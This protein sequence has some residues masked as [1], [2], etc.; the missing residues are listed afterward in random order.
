[1]AVTLNGMGVAH[2]HGLIAAGHYDD[3]ASWSFTADDGNALLGASGDDWANYAAFHLGV[4]GDAATDTK[5]RWDYPYG[6][7]GKVYGAALRAI[8]SRAAQQNETAIYD[9]AGHCLDL[10]KAAQGKSSGPII[11]RAYSALTIKAFDDSKR[12][13]SGIASTPSVD[14]MGDVVDPMGAVFT[15]P[16]PLLLDHNSRQ[17]VGHVT[18]AKPNA[19]GIPFTAQIA[20]VGEPGTVKDMVDGAWQLVKA[21]LRS[22]VSIGFSALKYE[23]MKDGGYQFN[24]W[25][26]LELSLVTIPANQDAVIFDGKS[27]GATALSV[28]KSID[29]TLLAASGK[30]QRNG[31]KR[32]VSAGVSATKPIPVVKAQ[33]A[34]PK[35]S[36]PVAD[37]ISAF[38]TTRTAK[39]ARM[40]EIMSVAA[41]KGETLDAAATEEYDTLEAE[42]KAIDE[43][44]VRLKRHEKT[45]VARAVD[46]SGAVDAAAASRV[47]AGLTVPAAVRAASS[48]PKGMGFTRFCMAV[49]R[50]KGNLMQAERMVSLN[51]RWMAETPDVIEV[52]RSAV[53]AGTTTD[54]TWAGP[55]VQYQNL[56]SEFIEYLRPLTIIGRIP[57]IRYVPFKV[58]IPRQTGKSTAGWV[59]EGQAK[60]VS[61]LA[62]DSVTMD[63][64]TISDI[65]IFSQQLA[66]LSQPSV[67]LLIR[68][69]LAKSIVNFMD[70]QFID[71]TV[72]ANGTTSPASVTNGLSPTVASGT[73]GDALRTDVGAL[74]EGFLEA[75]MQLNSACWVMSQVTA[76]RI[77]L[78]RNA[79]GQKEYPELNANGGLFEGFPA[80]TSQSVPATGGSPTDGYPMI[81]MNAG[82]ILIADDGQVRIDASSEASLQMDTA[83]DS[84]TT[85]STTLVSLWQQGY[86]GLKADRDINWVKRRSTAVAYISN[87]KY[88]TG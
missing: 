34:K 29:A 4:D 9:A 70:A 19:A 25:E 59:G 26:W 82:D 84:P 30:Q 23:I 33:E 5:A 44:L 45:N 86:M 61:S 12:E 49:A 60:P 56:V 51:E 41:E 88:T 35:M 42:V 71:P 1:M 13:F 37:Q 36:K 85:G 69:D 58:K 80:I 18:F 62:F 75:N 52:I 50:S 21:R 65:V 27:F 14:R 63:I 48:I 2:A 11:G 46:V 38:E 40:D 10:I 81:L 55:L 32:E 3:T 8:R 22:F 72:A 47:R 57:G 53:A 83:P 79:L 16:M 64:A 78:I 7:G 54:S 15:L 24:A 31:V 6:K 17:A 66:Q 68:D 77:N 20:S 39:S 74:I 76:A 43:H 87:A 73:T 28:V 67:E